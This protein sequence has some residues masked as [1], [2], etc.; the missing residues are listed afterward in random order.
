MT[1]TNTTITEGQ[2][3]RIINEDGLVI[4]ESVAESDT[5]AAETLETYR[6][7][8]CT[9]VGGSTKDGLRLCNMSDR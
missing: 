6:V 1:T 7:Y 2:E 8:Y 5:D 4:L 9:I 3:Y